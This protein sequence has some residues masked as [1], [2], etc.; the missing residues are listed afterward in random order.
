MKPVS[1]A[2]A[3]GAG[4][5]T[6]SL[7]EVPRVMTDIPPVHSLVAQVMAGVG[8]PDLL[9][10]GTASPHDFA[11][12]PSDAR[13]MQ[14]AGLIVE[15]GPDLTPWMADM[16]ASVAGDADHL[17]LMDLAETQVRSYGEHEDHGDHDDHAEHHD[18]DHDGDHG[19]HADDDHDDH[20][21]GDEHAH[22]AEHEHEH[23]HANEHE[24]EDEHGHDLDGDDPHVWLDPDNAIAWMPMIAERLSALDPDNS[25]TYRANA[26]DG[27]AAIEAAVADVTATLGEVSPRFLVSHDAFGY[28]EE[29]FDVEAAGEI[30]IGD[31]SDPGPARL[32]ALR[33]MAGEQ[34]I[35]CVLVEPQQSDALAGVVVPEGLQLGTIDALGAEIEPGPALYPTMLRNLAASIAGCADG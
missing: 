17:V 23:G 1:L 10:P 2:L 11:L 33:D 22:D 18:H 8:T 30:A 7:A 24:H 26:D 13:A 21:H 35:T 29:R 34:G 12:R 32:A 15:I 6:A 28:F 19:Y 27:V 9:I 4:T 16:I 14:D 25:G 31:A 3:L 20:E 5:A